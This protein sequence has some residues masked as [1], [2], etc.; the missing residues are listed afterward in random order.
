MRI[1]QIATLATTVRQKGSGSIEAMVWLLTH[2]LTK[3]GHEVTVFAA[4]GSETDGRLVSPLPGTYGQNDSPADWQVCEFINLCRAVE[5]SGEFDVLHSH[6]Y[7]NALMLER[8]SKAPVVNTM[9]LTGNEE[10]ARLWKQYPEACVTAISKYQWSGYPELQPAAV[11]YHG[12][13]SSQ[14]TYQATPEDYVCYLG[15]FT[16]GKGA[17][18]AIAAAKSLGI[19]LVLAGPRSDYYNDCI[20][21][22]VDGKSVEYVG[23]VGGT[24]RN[25]LLGKARALLYPVQHPEPFGLV[26]VEAMMCGTPVVAMNLGAVPEIIDQGITGNRTTSVEDFSNALMQTISLDRRLVRERA[27]TRFSQERMAHQYIEVYRKLI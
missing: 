17:L 19:R 14:F 24:R 13:D 15:R 2:E 11:I 25:E 8:L 27:V 6:S 23:T 12:V 4:A 5:M 1:A 18:Q 7:L 9:H 16:P 3:S 10:Y 26:M 20:E 21:P 22:L